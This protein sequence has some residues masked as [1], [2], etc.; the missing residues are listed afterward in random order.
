MYLRLTRCPLEIGTIM[1][2]RCIAFAMHAA[3]RYNRVAPAVI[4]QVGEGTP[5]AVS[6]SCHGKT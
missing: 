2:P 3:T 5:E 1:H 6:F 4:H